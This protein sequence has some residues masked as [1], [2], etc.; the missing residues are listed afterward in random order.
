MNNTDGVRNRRESHTKTKEIKPL[1]TTDALPTE[2]KRRLQTQTKI[3]R[4]RP[5]PTTPALTFHPFQ[6]R[7]RSGR[8]DPS[9]PTAR[10]SPDTSNG[11]SF[12]ERAEHTPHSATNELPFTPEPYDPLSH[13]RPR[14]FD[15]SVACQAPPNH[16]MNPPSLEYDSPLSYT[17]SSSPTTSDRSPTNFPEGSGYEIANFQI[18][19]TSEDFYHSHSYSPAVQGDEQYHLYGNV[20]VV[21]YPISYPDTN[22]G[23]VAPNAVPSYTTSYRPP[24][25]R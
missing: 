20:G 8:Q 13:T 14:A 6:N 10:Y 7:I 19:P 5:P 18:S 11:G 12:E 9:L 3:K 16:E 2:R 23:G 17:S 22:Y 21:N 15:P 24:P 4:T 25:S 1:F